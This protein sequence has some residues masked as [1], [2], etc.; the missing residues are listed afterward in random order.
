MKPTRRL[1]LGSDSNHR[2]RSTCELGPL[3]YR[4]QGRLCR[5][6]TALLSGQL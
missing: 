6:V 3:I 2:Q 1:K 5:L 4:K